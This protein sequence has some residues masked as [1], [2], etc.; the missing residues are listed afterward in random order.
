[1]AKKMA[2]IATKGAPEAVA[3]LCHLDADATAAITVQVDRMARSGQRVLG[4][5]VA[6]FD[7]AQRRGDNSHRKEQSRFLLALRRDVA[8]ALVL[9]RANW[10]EQREPADA[11]ILL[12][13]AVAARD[14]AAA[15]PVLDWLAR[16]GVESVALRGL[17]MKLKAAR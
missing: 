10:A 15:Q 4:V 8:Q 11:R 6:R 12:E 3:D 2:I 13:A 14:A 5:A 16:T 7:A 1:M 17:A 9:A